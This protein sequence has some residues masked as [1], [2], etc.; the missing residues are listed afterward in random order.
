MPRPAEFYKEVDS[1][2]RQLAANS[3]PENVIRDF[4]K[5]NNVTLDEVAVGKDKPWL[6]RPLAA[7]SDAAVRSATFGLSDKA[8]SGADALISK[9]PD[10]FKTA[11]NAMSDFFGA[12]KPYE[13]DPNRPRLG[14]LYQQNLAEADQVARAQQDRKSTRLNSSHVSESRMPSSA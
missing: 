9:T 10:Y 4:L 3:A 7:A 5:Y 12:G 2:I 11:I 6:L 14:D 8:E 13:L 1:T